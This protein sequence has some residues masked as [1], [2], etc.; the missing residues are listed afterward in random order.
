MAS[1]SQFWC[2]AENYW[3]DHRTT[4][5]LRTKMEWEGFFWARKI[6]HG[7]AA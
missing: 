4:V 2:D 6:G 5:L 3:V 1:T 7:I